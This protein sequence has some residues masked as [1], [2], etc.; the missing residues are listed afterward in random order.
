MSNVLSEKSQDSKVVET[1]FSHEMRAVVLW[2]SARIFAILASFCPKVHEKSTRK[3]RVMNIFM[4]R[5]NSWVEKSYRIRFNLIDGKYRYKKSPPKR[6]SKV[7][8]S[9]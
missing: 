7:N 5:I 3:E 1:E 6:A 9:D 2:G 4:T 8:E